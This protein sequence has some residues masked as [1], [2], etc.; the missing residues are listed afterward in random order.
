METKQ[1]KTNI[2]CGFCVAKV[3]PLLNEILGD[4]NWKVDT[5][6]PKKILTVTTDDA[7]ESDIPNALQKVGYMAEELV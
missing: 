3:T 1:F 5:H 2:M 7:K 6:N 4:N